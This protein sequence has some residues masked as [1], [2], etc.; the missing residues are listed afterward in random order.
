LAA[1]WLALPRHYL[2]GNL[3]TIAAF[4]LRR[5]GAALAVDSL[6]LS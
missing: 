6:L 1:F 4:L 2:G 5:E 3:G